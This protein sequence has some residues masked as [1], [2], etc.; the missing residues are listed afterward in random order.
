[1]ASIK[2]IKELVNN[3]EDKIDLLLINRLISP[4]DIAK[5]NDPDGDINEQLSA[6]NNISK[7]VKKEFSDSYL[8]NLALISTDEEMSELNKFIQSVDKMIPKSTSGLSEKL[9]AQIDKFNDI[10]NPDLGLVILRNQLEGKNDQDTREFIRNNSKSLEKIFN[11]DVLQNI[12][13]LEDAMDEEPEYGVDNTDYDAMFGR[14]N[15][16]DEFY[17][18]SMREI[19]RRAKKNGMTGQELLLRLQDAKIAKDREAI[20]H[21][22]WNKNDG[23]L[24]NL[25]NE[26]TGTLSTFFLPRI[27]EAIERGETPSE[28]DIA[29]DALENAAYATP[30]GGVGRL[31]KLAGATKYG[32]KVGSKVGSTV[33]NVLKASSKKSPIVKVTKA[34][35]GSTVGKGVSKVGRGA[36]SVYDVGSPWAANFV[37]PGITEVMDAVAYDGAYDGAD[38]PR[39]DFSMLDVG[40]GGL[41]NAA[42]PW[43]LRKGGQ[44]LATKFGGSR[45]AWGK[46][47]TLGEGQTTKEMVVPIRSGLNKKKDIIDGFWNLNNGKQPTKAQLLDY[48]QRLDKESRGLIE[49][50]DNYKSID[51]YFL[52][53][54]M[55]EL[56]YSSNRAKD[57]GHVFGV[58]EAPGEFLLPPLGES[59]I[60]KV[61]NYDKVR[62]KS[63][64]NPGKINTLSGN[65]EKIWNAIPELEATQSAKGAGQLISE[66]IGQNYLT[67][68]AGDVIYGN[69]EVKVAMPIPNV[70]I[71]NQWIKG[72]TEE[73]ERKKKKERSLKDQYK[74][75]GVLDKALEDAKKKQ[76]DEKQKAQKQMQG[77][78]NMLNPE[79]TVKKLYS[80]I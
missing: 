34:L 30:I 49:G 3:N 55:A 76:Q 46:L 18:L 19:E 22:R 64:T 61:G 25:A 66:L 6:F 65:Q 23:K 40:T 13:D 28:K 16:L 12:P 8:N 78:Y 60:G 47:G 20:A 58:A 38:N 14:K 17:D 21:G 74:G 10:D 68:K 70:N 1:M 29:L 36:K 42:T 35:G 57:R 26:L 75:E 32:S 4:D 37:V 63:K 33:G 62:P 51:E 9:I 56:L 7:A 52:D 27:Q 50:L 73:Q 54:P 44:G 45:G 24:T 43:F 69:E 72:I 77:V 39:G 80:N 53:N 41:V 59:G 67:N 48:R 71:V 31:A 15:V 79:M 11:K 5:I 2:E